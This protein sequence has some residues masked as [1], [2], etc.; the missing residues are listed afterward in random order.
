MSL[1]APIYRRG[2]AQRELGT[3]VRQIPF[4]VKSACFTAAP[5]RL[6]NNSASISGG[7]RRAFAAQ[8]FL[9]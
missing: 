8:S 5:S 1:P 2:R 7:L 3:K 4:E 6:F 9:E